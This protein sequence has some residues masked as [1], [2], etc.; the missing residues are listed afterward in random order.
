MAEN[1]QKEPLFSVRNLVVDYH[2]G[3]SIVHAVNYFAIAI[4]DI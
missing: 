1:H 2:S 4:D 3:D